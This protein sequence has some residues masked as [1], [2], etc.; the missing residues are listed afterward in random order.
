MEPPDHE[1]MTS[2]DP[3]DE[4]SSRLENVVHVFVGFT[5]LGQ[6]HAFAARKKNIYYPVVVV[7]QWPLS[8]L[9]YNGIRTGV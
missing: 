5:L 6:D 1:A 9:C 7:F 3:N 2:H 4:D 8:V